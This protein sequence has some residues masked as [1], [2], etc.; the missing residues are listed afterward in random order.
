MSGDGQQVRFKLV[1]IYWDF[2]AG[3]GGIGV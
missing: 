3:L 1:N 2:A